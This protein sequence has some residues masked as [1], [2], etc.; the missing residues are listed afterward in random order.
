[1]C[2]KLMTI[3]A[4]ALILAALAV[5]EQRL[6]SHLTDDA[7]AKTS[8]ILGLIR[9]GEMETALQKARELDLHW[10]DHAGEL[11]VMVDH[12]STDEVRYG[13]SRLIAA[14]EAEDRASALIYASEVEG[15][16]EHVRERQA[17]SVQNLL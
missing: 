6:V 16:V 14:L 10:D 9:E 13:L 15:G 7:L 11:E 3:L 1:M 4:T 12:S 5:V 2:R 17:F 8:V